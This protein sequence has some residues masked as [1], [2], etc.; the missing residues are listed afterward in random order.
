M[1]V[2]RRWQDGSDKDSSATNPS[3][4]ST[5]ITTFCTGLKFRRYAP[6]KRCS[7]ANSAETRKHNLWQVNHMA[8][9]VMDT[10]SQ[11]ILPPCLQHPPVLFLLNTQCWNTQTNA[12]KHKLTYSCVTLIIC[13]T[14]SYSWASPHIQKCEGV[15]TLF[16][17]ADLSHNWAWN[18]NNILIC[19][20]T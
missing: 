8:L 20:T 16:Q 4:S 13:V 2:C 12:N 15:G 1:M 14:H 10:D 6:V 19:P 18:H 11:I 7:G 17:G 9:A 5:T 3:V